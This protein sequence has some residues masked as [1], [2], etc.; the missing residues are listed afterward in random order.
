MVVTHLPAMAIVVSLKALCDGYRLMLTDIGSM[1]HDL[2]GC[3]VGMVLGCDSVDSSSF[4]ALGEDIV[5]D[6]QKATNVIV[7]FP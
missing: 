2:A 3:W 7:T 1:V 4:I 5:E 6:I